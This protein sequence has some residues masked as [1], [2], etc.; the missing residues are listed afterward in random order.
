MLPREITGEMFNAVGDIAETSLGEDVTVVGRTGDLS[1][2]FIQTQRDG[3]IIFA[4]NITYYSGNQRGYGN[5]YVQRL[6]HMPPDNDPRLIK[7]SVYSI[8]NGWSPDETW[9]VFVGAADSIALALCEQRL[10]AYNIVT[11]EVVSLMPGSDARICSVRPNL[12]WEMDDGDTW[13]LFEAWTGGEQSESASYT[14]YRI[15]FSPNQ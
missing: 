3:H 2:S 14:P 13:I 8:S 10:Y 12:Q 6:C 15:L 7:S 9:F 1:E 5:T 11:G 4:C